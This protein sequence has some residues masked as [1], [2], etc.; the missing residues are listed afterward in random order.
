M[1]RKPQGKNAFSYLRINRAAEEEIQ[2]FNNNVIHMS[3]STSDNNNNKKN[4]YPKRP[5]Q[6]K[7]SNGSYEVNVIQNTTYQ[8]KNKNNF[9]NKK[10]N[11]KSVILPIKKNKSGIVI[12]IYSRKQDSEKEDLVINEDNYCYDNE[13]Q[14]EKDEYERLR[15]NKY[16]I[17]ESDAIDLVREIWIKKNKIIKAINLDI[18]GKNY[19][20]NRNAKNKIVK[21]T[22]FFIK[23]K[24]KWEKELTKEL[25]NFFTIYKTSSI[26][27]FKYSEANYIRDLS[28]SIF[29][30]KDDDNNLYI[31]N[32]PNNFQP[33][34]KIN[35]KLIK[36]KDRN[37]LE[38]ELFDYYNKNKNN[39]YTNI[40]NNDDIEEQKLR[41]I[42]ALSKPQIDELYKELNPEKPKDWGLSKN[43]LI[44]SPQVA[45]DYEIIEIYTPKSNKD[46]NTYRMKG[47]EIFFDSNIRNENS[48]KN[49][50]QN[51]GQYTPISMLNDK[52]FV[53][54]ISRNI[55]YSVPES[56]GFINYLNYDKYSKKEFGKNDLQKNKFSLKIAR[57]NKFEN[58]N[59]KKNNN[60]IDYSKYSSGSDKNSKN[61]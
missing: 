47:N 37:K 23:S 57:M 21:G 10:D 49:S 8:T 22:K 33:A 48:I 2:K 45:L 3:Y 26:D 34:H 55:K 39:Y 31:I 30:P 25:E 18:S 54:A 20:K 7:Y 17:N 32:P 50:S 44:I 24:K 46:N 9:S 53:Y 15:N 59:K 29:L 38:S 11:N 19:L 12:N 14:T 5:N 58:N 41:P 36:P 27:R 13:N 61:K 40:D 6:T 60:V 42:Y 52:F 28:N 1:S 51:F 16:V 4:I 56:Q 43:N 35:Y